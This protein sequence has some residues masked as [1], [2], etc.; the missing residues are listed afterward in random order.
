MRLT[1]KQFGWLGLASLAGVV[2]GCQMAH[3]IA[4]QYGGKNADWINKTLDLADAA[5]PIDKV[6]A[7]K[8]GRSTAIAITNEYKVSDN[9]T[10][11]VYVNYIGQ[12]LAASSQHPNDHYIFGVLDKD[13]EVGAFSGPE[14]YIFITSGALKKAQDES[15]VAGLLA[16]EMTH[17]EKQHSLHS[18]Q[19]GHVRQQVM[20]IVSA[21]ANIQQALPSIDAGVDLITNVGYS[22]PQELEADQGAV[23]LLMAA[24]YDPHGML[25]FMQ[26]IAQEQQSNP[27]AKIMATHPDM[28]ER[29]GLAQKQID[30]AGAAANGGATLAE[31]FKANVFAVATP[32]PAAAQPTTTK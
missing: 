25:H 9:Q 20:A 27:S 22:Q 12:T 24:G 31:R 13:D 5:K 19:L 16:H 28:S 26:R 10:Q 17:V 18:I 11:Q 4:T 8:Y 2:I 30:A 21:A 32:A 6:T 3:Q 14:G 23:Q 7:D 29:A 1:K 15:E